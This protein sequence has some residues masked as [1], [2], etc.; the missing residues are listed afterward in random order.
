M[1]P[2]D[3]VEPV[4]HH[5][6][7]TCQD[8]RWTIEDLAAFVAEILEDHDHDGKPITVEVFEENH[9]LVELRRT[10]DDAF[11]VIGTGAIYLLK[12]GDGWE[13]FRALVA[14]VE[15][16]V[17]QGENFASLASDPSYREGEEDGFGVAMQRLEALLRNFKEQ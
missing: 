14:A 17:E 3:H 5:L 16:F 2:Q 7:F 1:N 9:E 4:R 6:T 11:R 8:P 13:K 12:Q 15:A 10:R